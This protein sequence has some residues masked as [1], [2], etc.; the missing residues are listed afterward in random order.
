[1]TVS[2]IVTSNVSP[3]DIRLDVLVMATCM[4]NVFLYNHSLFDPATL[5]EIAHGLETVFQHAV[6][7]PHILLTELMAHVRQEMHARS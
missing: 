3:Y 1:M 5:A 7:N 6:N 2:P 4:R